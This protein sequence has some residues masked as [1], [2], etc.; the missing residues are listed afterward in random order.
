MP[1]GASRRVRGVQQGSDVSGPFFRAA[2]IKV[3][4]V[5]KIA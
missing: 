5:R 2:R 1:E 4:L 3:G